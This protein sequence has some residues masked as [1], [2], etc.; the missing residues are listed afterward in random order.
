[1]PTTN[2]PIFPQTIVN[3]A[4]LINNATGS[5]S[6]NKVT[7][8]AGSTNGDK[9]ESIS[10]T[11]TDTSARVLT[12]GMTISAT[13]YIIGT[14]NVP[15]TAG[16]DAAATAAVSLL[17]NNSI[18]LWIRKDNNGRPYIYVASGSTLFA[19]AQTTVTSGKE[20]DIFTQ[21]GAF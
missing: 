8:R 20:I 6:A 7:I 15:I 2:T 3:T 1:M 16:T 11:S 14:V 18:L 4:V 10:I 13:D 9:I 5:G 17:E 12:I 19:Y 21:I